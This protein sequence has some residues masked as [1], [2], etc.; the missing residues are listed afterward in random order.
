[1]EIEARLKELALELGFSSVGIASAETPLHHDFLTDWVANGY[2]GEMGYMARHLALRSGA[3]NLLEGARSVIATT[4]AYNQPNPTVAGMPR[5]AR[6]ALGRD[7]HKV[8]GAK[9]RGLAR[10]LESLAPGHRFRACVDSAPILEREYAHQAGLGWFGKNTMLIDSRRGSW[11]FI[12]LLLTTLPLRPDRAAEGGCGTCRLCLDA[13]PT[14]AIVPFDG[15]TT[16][17]ARRCISYLT[18]EQKSELTAEQEAM[19]G[20]WTFGCDVC[21][22]VCPFN[23]TRE[24]QPLRGEATRELDFLAKRTWPSLEALSELG[25]EDWDAI[26]QGS[27]VRRAKLPRLRQVARANLRNAKVHR[28]DPG[29]DGE[30]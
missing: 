1:M 14:G 9:L 17:D 25:E 21:Q 4:L 26:T 7:Y 18:I 19:V 27:P 16:V 22:E 20:D 3:A 6:Y 28:G 29:A 5:I 12:G 23:R 30:R 8:L 10:E 11:F 15:R 2:H 24:S 13:C